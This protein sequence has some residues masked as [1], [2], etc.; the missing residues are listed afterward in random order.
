M[1]TQ[2]TG[3]HHRQF[4]AAGHVPAVQQIIALYAGELA[5][6][7]KANDTLEGRDLVL[8]Q[9]RAQTISEFLELFKNAAANAEAS[10]RSETSPGRR[11]AFY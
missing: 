9:G 4:A 2:L 11:S 1:I 5:A 8:S 6:V 7:R 3:E 10:Q